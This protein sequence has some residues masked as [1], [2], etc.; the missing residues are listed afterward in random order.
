[1]V[2]NFE[3]DGDW[4]VDS[5]AIEHITNQVDLLDNKRRN[6]FETPVII[7]N[8]DNVPVEGRGDYVLPGGAEVKEVLYVP[9]FNCN[10]LSVSR[11]TKNLQCAVTF[12]PDFCVVQGLRSGNLIGADECR[13][14]LYRMGIFRNERKAKMVTMDRWHKR[15]GHPSKEKLV[16]MTL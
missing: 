10:L 7:P 14:G 1:M 6:S 2:V 5:G 8:G 16:Q 11:L 12:F 9:K 4:I 13:R 3:S 15:L